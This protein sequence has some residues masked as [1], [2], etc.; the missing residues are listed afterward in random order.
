MSVEDPSPPP[1][2]ERSR[3]RLLTRFI[4]FALL[5][6]VLCG[7]GAAYVSTRGERRPTGA[8]APQTPEA[9]YAVVIRKPAGPPVFHVGTKDANGKSVTMACAE[10]HKTRQP[11][12][13][14]RLGRPMAFFHQ[15]LK[16][17]HGN[18]SCVACHNPSDGNAT[19][20]FADGTALPYTEVMQLCGQCHGPQYR[21]YQ[22]GAH[23]GMTGY[24]DLSKGGRTRANCID[25]HTPHA[26]KYQPVQP[27]KGPN[28]RGSAKAKEA[29]HRE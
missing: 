12:A 6:V 1:A 2:V 8:A 22:H 15:D 11:N 4:P 9:R 29:A 5:G 25:C 28:D 16:G 21:D 13:E 26:P 14:N 19:L 7:A 20:R 23:G 24:W 10:C 18:L 17:A 3:G 27:A